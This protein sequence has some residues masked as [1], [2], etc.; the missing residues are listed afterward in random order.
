MFPAFMFSEF[1][2]PDFH[3]AF[4]GNTMWIL[5]CTIGLLVAGVH[6]KSL[7]LLLL[8]KQWSCVTVCQWKWLD[9]FGTDTVQCC[10]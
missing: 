4:T 8:F 1:M 2:F 3:A 9:W 7:L 10:A 6:Y 5:E